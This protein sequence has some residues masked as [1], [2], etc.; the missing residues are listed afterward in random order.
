LTEQEVTT[1]RAGMQKSFYINKGVLRKLEKISAQK[2][3]SLNAYVNNVLTREVDLNILCRSVYPSTVI[4]NGLLKALLDRNEDV[5][6][7]YARE[8][9]AKIFRDAMT[10]GA[11]RDLT[12]FR[13]YVRAYCDYGMWADY[14]EQMDPNKDVIILS[15]TLGR[16]WSRFMYE[17]F[18][19]G[20]REIIGED[21]P[22]EDVFV[23]I[24]SALVITL[25][26]PTLKR[27]RRT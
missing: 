10:L 26:P 7:S 5:F 8:W 17:Y 11:S 20:L 24:E 27:Y 16:A 21:F 2:K 12:T 14:E 1:K 25:P 18:Y 23:I 9:S 19:H 3:I 4:E 6:L 15:H 13:R 22:P